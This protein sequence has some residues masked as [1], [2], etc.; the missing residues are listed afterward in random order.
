MVSIIVPLMPIEPYDGQVAKCLELLQRQT[1]NKEIIVVEQPVERY[2][3][4]N[5]LLNSGFR[6][7]VGDK[8]FHCDVDF[9]LEDETLLKRMSDK[10][11]AENLD[12][13]YPKFLSHVSRKLKIADGG[14][15]MQQTALLKYGPL[16]ESLMGI[17][18]VTFPL[19]NHLFNNMKFHCSDE[20]IIQVD[21]R[22]GNP[23]RRN[24][25]TAKRMR[26]IF[27]ETVNQLKKVGAWPV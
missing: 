18:W 10:L 13:I 19:L 16:N 6:K 24:G 15:F 11:D 1:V 3:N 25:Q 22:G 17:S 21:T 7:S 20:F 14:P 8:V 27:K 2:I 23:K 5:R 12:V 9:R 26:P 4:K